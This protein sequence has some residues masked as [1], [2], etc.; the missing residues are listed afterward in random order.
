LARSTQASS[1]L[2]IGL[3][4]TPDVDSVQLLLPRDGVAEWRS[5]GEDYPSI[6]DRA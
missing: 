1:L 4:L 2:L 6:K 3:D 5:D